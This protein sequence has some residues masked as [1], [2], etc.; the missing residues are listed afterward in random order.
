MNYGVS[1]VIPAYNEVSCL[2]N[3]ISSIKESVSDLRPEIIVIDNGSTDDTARV[4]TMHEA[5]VRSIGRSTVAA[6]RNLGARMVESEVVVFIDAD[7]RLTGLWG[8]ELARQI[9]Y[10]R[11][12]RAITG[13]RCIIP[14]SPTWIEKYWFCP[15]SK[16]NVSYINSAN[17]IVNRKAFESIGGFNE[18]L[19]TGED[20]DFS[21]RA[22]ESGISVL[23]NPNYEAIHDGYPR[24][25]TGFFKRELWHGK[26][27]F[28]S[29]RSFIKSHVAWSAV[30]FGTTQSLLLLS[31]L[32]GEMQVAALFLVLSG[33]F[34]LAISTKLFSGHGLAFVICNLPLCYTYLAARFL[35]LA[36]VSVGA[37]R[38]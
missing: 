2:G 5:R 4:A 13:A 26:G 38:K 30:F 10:L 25:L 37:L 21:A 14:E 36:S 20:Y 12:S 9:Q 22:K 33:L 1:F 3:A 16:K 18:L 27:D 28:S 32:A 7:T 19:E 31:L 34:L 8:K 29:I 6:A 11:E 35:S 23:V 15:L 24:N 17:L